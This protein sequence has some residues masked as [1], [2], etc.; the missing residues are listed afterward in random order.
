MTER[1]KP[2]NLDQL[3]RPVLLVDKSKVLRNVDRMARKARASAVLLRP[4]FK[5]HQSADLAEW[6]RSLGI[7]KITVSSVDMAEYFGRNGW[8]DIT[9]AVPVNIHQ[10]PRINELAKAIDLNVIIDS[11]LAA[12]RLREGI[13]VP[14]NVWIEI[15]TGDHRTGISA[16]RTD[17]I[18][19]VAAT[20]SQAPALRFRGLLT[21]DGHSYETKGARDILRIHESSRASLQDVKRAL[22]EAGY[23]Q[24]SVSVG[25]TP[26]CTIVDRFLPPI[27]E[28]RPGNFV[29]YD[30][31][32]KSLGICRDE[33]IAVAIA[34]PIISKNPEWKELVI[35][36]GSVHVSRESLSLPSG[37]PFFGQI[38]R[39]DEDQAAWTAPIPG[40]YL[41]ALSQEHGKVAGPED[42][43]RRMEIGD[44]LIILPIHSC[45]TASLYS[46]YHVLNGGVLRKFRA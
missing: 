26:S 25:D 35:Y 20:L 29:F 6:M 17:L 24:L 3:E 15:D 16:E 9:I 34:C 46:E 33:D 21:H 10:I 19:K 37:K 7:H 27:D 4:H 38:A 5:T 11:E 36:G 23:H 41:S 18:L 42:F 31:Q 13:T 40:A 44:T 45:I 2:M 8:D 22:E 14:L 39:L 43:I 1:N 28:I 32:Q 12:F 30:V